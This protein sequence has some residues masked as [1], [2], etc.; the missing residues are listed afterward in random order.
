MEGRSLPPQSFDL[1]RHVFNQSTEECDQPTGTHK[2]N[3]GSNQPSNKR[4]VKRSLSPIDSGV[5]PSTPKHA[6]LGCGEDQSIG[7]Y[8]SG[9]DVHDDDVIATHLEVLEESHQDV[10]PSSKDP[11]VKSIMQVYLR[12]QNSLKLIKTHVMNAQHFEQREATLQRRSCR[13]AGRRVT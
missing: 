2:P 7:D 12:S 6:K 1:A 8:F 3:G 11:V 5:G 9:I 10:M 13:S 4:P